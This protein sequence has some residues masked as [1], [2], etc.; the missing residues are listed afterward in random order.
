VV[1]NMFKQIIK[2]RNKNKLMRYRRKKTNKTNYGMCFHVE[3]NGICTGKKKMREVNIHR[4][5]KYRNY[6]IWFWISEMLQK[7]IN[8]CLYHVGGVSSASIER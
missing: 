8:V 2:K 5:T 6:S 3:K 1:N 4:I 7:F